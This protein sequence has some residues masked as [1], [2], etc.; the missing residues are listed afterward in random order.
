MDLPLVSDVAMG[1]L[2]RSVSEDGGFLDDVLGPNAL[3]LDAIFN[4]MPALVG[5]NI[6]K[7]VVR[8]GR[9]PNYSRNKVSVGTMEEMITISDMAMLSWGFENLY[10]CVVGEVENESAG[11][12][13]DTSEKKRSKWTKTATRRFGGWSDQGKVHWNGIMKDLKERWG[14]QDTTLQMAKGDFKRLFED[15]WVRLYG[16]GR[17]GATDGDNRFP[18]EA[19]E[20][21]MVMSIE[22]L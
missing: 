3:L 16:F 7:G 8:C 6:W 15:R 11:L 21:D 4:L 12:A 18:E 10:D 9:H 2:K 13:D 17:G 20:H 14:E 19:A 22:E 5:S 1:P